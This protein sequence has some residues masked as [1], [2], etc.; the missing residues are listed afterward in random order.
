MLSEDS[1]G[2]GCGKSVVIG[3]NNQPV[4]VGRRLLLRHS[5]KL[6]IPGFIEIGFVVILY[7]KVGSKQ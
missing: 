4:V 6:A 7:E 1:W 5:S 3:S 2:I